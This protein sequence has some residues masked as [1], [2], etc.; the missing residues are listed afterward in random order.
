MVRERCVYLSLGGRVGSGVGW[1][2]IAWRVS[3]CVCVCVCVLLSVSVDVCFC[4]R[5]RR[6]GCHVLV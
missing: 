1:L 5:S 2:C 3:P 4:I 6:I